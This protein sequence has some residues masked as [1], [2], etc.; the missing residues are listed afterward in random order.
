MNQIQGIDSPRFPV[1]RVAGVI[2]RRGGKFE[3]N[4]DTVHDSNRGNG[5]GIIFPVESNLFRQTNRPKDF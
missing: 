3:R 4:F 1:D 5:R 2:V